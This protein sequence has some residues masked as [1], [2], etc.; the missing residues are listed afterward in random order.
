MNKR[1]DNFKQLFGN[2]SDFLDT[3][4]EPIVYQFMIKRTAL[5]KHQKEEINGTWLH[6]S[7]GLEDWRFHR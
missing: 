5:S 7:G 2:I 3:E 1:Q 4:L 6:P